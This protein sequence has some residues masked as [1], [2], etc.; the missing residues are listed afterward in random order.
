MIK[1]FYKLIIFILSFSFLYSITYKA[2]PYE[3]V[4]HSLI[5][6]GEKDLEI[7]SYINNLKKRKIFFKFLNEDKLYYRELSFYEKINPDFIKIDLSEKEIK[8]INSSKNNL[9]TLKKIV[10]KNNKI[11]KTEIMDYYIEPYIKEENV[12]TKIRDG[13]FASSISMKQDKIITKSGMLIDYI[14]SDRFLIREIKINKESFDRNFKNV[15][16]GKNIITKS[17]IITGKK[18]KITSKEKEK[19]VLVFYNYDIDELKKE[20]IMYCNV[21]Q[22]CRKID[23]NSDKIKITKNIDYTE[24][25][26]NDNE[27]FYVI[28]NDTLITKISI[29]ESPRYA[30]FIPFDMLYISDFNYFLKLIEINPYY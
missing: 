7:S 25:K 21:Y 12:V 14:F 23:L 15:L 2:N 11:D 28:E 6:K 3:V 4:D 20:L 1:K 19:V 17:S 18:S 26:I 27:G 13:F 29:R 8:N 16:N 30:P 10:N 24:V 5:G 22:V 9:K